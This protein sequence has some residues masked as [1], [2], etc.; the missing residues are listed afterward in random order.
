MK[1]E[2]LRIL[3]GGLLACCQAASVYAQDRPSRPNRALFGGAVSGP[4]TRQSLDLT[5]TASQAF[6]NNLL[7]D[8][9]GEVSDLSSA[10]LRNGSYSGMSAEGGYSW[11]GQHTQFTANASYD[12]RYYG[13]LQQ[14]VG[15]NHFGAVAVSTDLGRRTRLLALQSARYTPSFFLYGVLPTL[16]AAPLS[17]VL[18]SLQDLGIPRFDVDDTLARPIPEAGGALAS[19][20]HAIGDGSNLAV[21]DRGA[22]A[23]DDRGGYLYNSYVVLSRGLTSRSSLALLGEYHSSDYGGSKL[24]RDPGSY[25]VGG[26]YFNNLSRSRAVHLGYVYRRGPS[27]LIG[28]RATTMHDIDAGFDVQPSRRTR[29]SLRT[30]STVVD[31]PGLDTSETGRFQYGLIGSANLTRDFRRTW[32]AGATYNRG[33]GFSEAFVGPVRSEGIRGSLDGL[34]SRRVDFRADAGLSWGEPNAFRTREVS[35]LART[36][37]SSRWAIFAD[38]AYLDVDL[39]TASVVLAPLGIPGSLKRNAIRVGVSLWTPLLRR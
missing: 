27:G 39:T 21:N 35:I 29:I 33:L 18:S 11:N 2:L 23:L 1:T 31:L 25:G 13:D 28:G 10:V 9:A 19:S 22:Y 26:R 14:L 12:G 3:A 16:T 7:I 8:F 37:L 38:Y 36:A 20:Q 32:R 30:G 24:L 17:D 5:L 34:L 6:D 4:A 15:V